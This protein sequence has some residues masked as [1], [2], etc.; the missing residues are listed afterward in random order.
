[1]VERGV[2]SGFWRVFNGI[3]AIVYVYLLVRFGPGI[4]GAREWSFPETGLLLIAGGCM[5]MKAAEAAFTM[6]TGSHI[7]E[8]AR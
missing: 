5:L 6:W 2:V 1:M 4:W 7:W 8:A 3:E